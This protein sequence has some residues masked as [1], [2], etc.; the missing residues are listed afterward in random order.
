[1]A[2]SIRRTEEDLSRETQLL[3]SR[4]QG[5][6]RDV[7]GLYYYF[8]YIS[9]PLLAAISTGLGMVLA[10][11]MK[12]LLVQRSRVS[13]LSDTSRSTQLALAALCYSALIW[14]TLVLLALIVLPGRFSLAR[15]PEFLYMLGASFLY[16]LICAS[17]TLFITSFSINTSVI[18]GVSNVV[19][20][21]SSFLGGIFV[22]RELLGENVLRIG[23]L[24]PAYWYT[25]AVRSIGDA[26][27][28][29]GS[30]LSTYW[31]SL[32]IALLMMTVLLLG[33]MVVNK[34]KSQRGI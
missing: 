5:G 18:T 17:I 32:G 15:E 19:A 4:D 27:E 8:V 22:P 7:R 24:L 12:Q 26:A 28:L 11:S 33:A 14:L 1:M 9:Y 6:R 20:L 31:N 34:Y 30:A 13:S 25:T 2:E 29:S 10:A 16:M 23:K 21:G 3:P